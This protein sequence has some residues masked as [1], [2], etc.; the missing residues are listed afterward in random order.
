MNDRTGEVALD[1]CS[2]NGL[3]EEDTWLRNRPET[4]GQIMI[5]HKWLAFLRVGI[6]SN[7][8][9]CYYAFPIIRQIIELK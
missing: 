7:P 2:R 3:R 4:D 5:V 8:D 6:D 9:E 1:E